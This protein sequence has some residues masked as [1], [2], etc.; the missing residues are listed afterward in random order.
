MLC[1]VFYPDDASVLSYDFIIL[2]NFYNNVIG[3]IN[4][5][6]HILIYFLNFYSY[7]TYIQIFGHLEY[8]S[9]EGFFCTQWLE[10]NPNVLI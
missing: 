4:N 9:P 10:K 1:I 6:N 3:L 2:I 8:L 7:F 5:T